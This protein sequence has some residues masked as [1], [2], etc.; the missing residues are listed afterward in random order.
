MSERTQTT[1]PPKRQPSRRH[2]AVGE[3]SKGRILEAAEKVLARDGY[4]AFS[5]RRVAQEC[6]ISVGNLTYYFPTKDSLIEALM[7]AIYDR[8][9]RRYAELVAAEGRD[10]PGELARLVTEML[11]DAAD[12]EATGLFLELSL[13]A[14]HHGFG[15]KILNRF[16]ER[17]ARDIAEAMSHEFPDRSQHELLQAAYFLSIIADGVCTVFSRLEDRS[18]GHDEIVSLAIEAIEGFLNRGDKGA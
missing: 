12:P 4:H 13:M 3:A 2:Y 17:W 1:A 5:A 15:A 18:V 8:Y 7:E 10:S 9:E 6:S 16:Y 11:R 14:R